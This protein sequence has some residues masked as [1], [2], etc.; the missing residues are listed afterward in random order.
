MKVVKEEE[1]VLLQPMIRLLDRRKEWLVPA[2]VVGGRGREDRIKRLVHDVWK[3]ILRE[4]IGFIF[5]N[6]T[7]TDYYVLPK[8]VYPY[9]RKVLI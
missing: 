9:V 8:Y 6:K 3:L 2:H 7:I 1:S 5:Y 4:E